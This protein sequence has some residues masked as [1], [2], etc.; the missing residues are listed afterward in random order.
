M[1]R[2]CLLVVACVLLLGGAA[3]GRAQTIGSWFVETTKT[4]FLAALSANASGNVLGQFC[5]PDE[6]SCVWLIGLKT[7][8]RRG[9]R[10]PVLANSDAGSVHLHVL[11]DGQLEGGL[12]RYAFTNFD[13]VDN[14]V[15]RGAR[16]GFAVPLEQDEFRVI[17]FDLAG[18]TGALA[19]MRAAAERRAQPVRRG[20]R[21]ERL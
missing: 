1:T 7:G 17:R 9:E 14:I 8:C 6:G 4:G 13:Q 2:A 16:V 11:C 12:F 19:V 18:A 3:A 21:D 10:Y 20:T 5:Y 15:R